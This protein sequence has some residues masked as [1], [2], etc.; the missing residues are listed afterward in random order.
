MNE[1]LVV[2]HDDINKINNNINSDIIIRDMDDFFSTESMNNQIIQKSKLDAE[3]LLNLQSD[4]ER[5]IH[6]INA[7]QKKC[8]P[9]A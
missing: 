3:K 9:K 1:C 2:N 8:A 4:I 6:M 5:I 7:A